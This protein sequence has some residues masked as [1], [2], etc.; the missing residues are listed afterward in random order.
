MQRQ[1]VSLENAPSD[2]SV[3][4]RIIAAAR[5]HF[6]THGFR[7]VT[8][9]DLAQDLGMSKKTLYAH[10]AGKNALLEAILQTKF[11]EA[12]AELASITADCPADFVT[13]LH[14]L[15][16]C[17][18]K[19]TEEIQPPFVRDIQREAPELFQLVERRRRD[20]IGRYFSK[21][22]GEGRRE[23]LIRRDIPVSI[24]IEILLGTISSVI[25]PPKL[26]ELGLTVKGGFNAIITMFLEGAVTA[27]G[28]TKI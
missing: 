13:A 11:S 24:M 6:F 16:A 12:E 21:L 2:Q 25:N 7:G 18:Q 4:R 10:F 23:G 17:A 15:L 19:H 28:K 5:Q 1:A 27:E 20:V 8:M 22:L 14:R 9:D 3:R 26:A